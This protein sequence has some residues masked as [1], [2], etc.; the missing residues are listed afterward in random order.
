MKT[1]LGKKTLNKIASDRISFVRFNVLEFTDKY[2]MD[3]G[4]LSLFEKIRQ[5]FLCNQYLRA[6]KVLADR[7]DENNNTEDYVAEFD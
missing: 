2:K 1:I 6:G 4:G 7:K 5:R 3:T